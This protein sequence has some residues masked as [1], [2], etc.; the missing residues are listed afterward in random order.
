MQLVCWHPGYSGL[1]RTKHTMTNIK[2]STS[3]T[4]VAVVLIKDEENPSRSPKYLTQL[5]GS[6]PHMRLTDCCGAYSS[7]S[8]RD[9]CCKECYSVVADGQGDGTEWLPEEYRK[10]AGELIRQEL[11]GPSRNRGKAAQC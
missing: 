7:H 1:N 6:N 8:G 9:L 3:W 10:A 4:G 5:D 11:A 2:L